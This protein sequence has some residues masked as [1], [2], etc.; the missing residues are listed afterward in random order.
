MGVGGFG[1][2]FFFFRKNTNYN[3]SHPLHPYH[4]DF[5]NW[6]EL[7]QT[8][9]GSMNRNS[10]EGVL[11]DG[12]ALGNRLH[13]CSRGDLFCP[14][15]DRLEK[16]TKEFYL[17]PLK[18]YKSKRKMEGT[19]RIRGP[20]PPSPSPSECGHRNPAGAQVQSSSLLLAVTDKENGQ[21]QEV[22]VAGPTS[23]EQGVF[24]DL[25]RYMAWEFFIF[26]F[27]YKMIILKLEC[28]CSCTPTNM[29]TFHT[30]ILQT[31]NFMICELCLSRVAYE[32]VA[33]QNDLKFLLPKSYKYVTFVGRLAWVWLPSVWSLLE[34]VTCYCCRSWREQSL[35]L[36]CCAV[37]GEGEVWTDLGQ[38]L[39]LPGLCQTPR[40]SPRMACWP[41][42]PQVSGRSS[43]FPN[44]SFGYM[45]SQ[46]AFQKF[47]PV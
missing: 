9:E 36:R 41:V 31:G 4:A 12:T 27:E 17:R 21:R 47:S 30:S 34:A 14:S 37:R 1:E 15:E 7:W 33:S 18:E 6:D 5:K 2:I 26:S 24:P 16:R 45:Q 13:F 23:I 20:L 29:P 22:A 44:R 40:N 43:S 28:S 10:W 38:W 19:K 35:H 46:R 11:P 8:K 39:Q 42:S 32:M 25:Q 3:F